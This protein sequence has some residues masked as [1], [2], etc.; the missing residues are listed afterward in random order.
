MSYAEFAYKRTVHSSTNCSPFEVEYGFNQLTFMDLIPLP[1]N[2]QGSLDGKKKAE[3]VKEIHKRVKQQIEKKNQQ[4][5]TQA[6]KG[7]RRV[8]FEPGDWVWVHMR[9]ERFP[10]QRKSKL[11]PWRD[12]PFQVIQRINDNVYKIDL[13]VKYSVNDTF[14][15][16]DLSPYD[17]GEDLRSNPFEERG[18]DENQE[19]KFN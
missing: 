10:S 5:A 12:K 19:L 2:E 6:N 15:V 18:D 11:A 13:L 17:A 8:T 14:N 9:K 3:K 7:R 1:I 4:H 16:S